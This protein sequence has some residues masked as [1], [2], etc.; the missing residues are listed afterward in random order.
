MR[1][2]AIRDGDALEFEEPPEEFPEPELEAE[3]EAG[4]TA[5]EGDALTLLDDDDEPPWQDSEAEPAAAEDVDEDMTPQTVAGD[6]STFVAIDDKDL[7]S[8]NIDQLRTA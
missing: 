7:Q 8:V 3:A 2:R 4:N 5:D 1:L 6:D